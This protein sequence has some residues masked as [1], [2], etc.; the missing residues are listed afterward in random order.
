M[1]VLIHPSSPD[2]HLFS[3]GGSGDSEVAFRDD[4]ERFDCV[5]IGL[6]NNMPDSALVSTERQLFDLLSAAAGKSIVRLHLFTMDATPRT[7][8]GR[9][10]V[11]RFYRGFNELFESRLDGV[12]ITGA[13]PTTERLVDE[14][15]WETFVQVVDWAKEN[16]AS[17]I[18]SCLAVHGAVQHLDGVERHPLASK[19][20]GV[21]DQTKVAPHPLMR[22]VPERLRIPH[23]RWNQVRESALMQSGYS[24]LTKSGAAGVD[25]FI[26]QHKRSLF[27]CF[28]GHPEYES[29]TLL[30]EYRRDIGRY[31]RE[32]ND[33][34]PNM[35]QGYFDFAA[36]E[37]LAAFEREALSGRRPE[38]LASF[39]V[40]RLARDLKNTWRIAAE[41]IYRNWISY[42]SSQKVRRPGLAAM[43][44]AV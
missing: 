38:L 24:V 22:G 23:S 20:I 40:D 36:Q 16:T 39:P 12:I 35:P 17:S 42:L 6:I 13:E 32:E 33:A 44:T 43:G 8:W 5:D 21:F 18:C 1:P 34:Y 10:Y 2:H 31:L 28:Q 30:G 29:Q 14:P 4:A 41:C 9:E 37:A 19:C 15:Y 25:C 3:R 11:R 26:K 27:V 7:T